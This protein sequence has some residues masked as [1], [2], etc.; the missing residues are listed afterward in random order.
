M[1]VSNNV[2]CRILTGSIARCVSCFCRFSVEAAA[3]RVY[4]GD[5]FFGGEHLR[6]PECGEIH[7]PIEGGG[8]GH[9]VQSQ[10]FQNKK[11]QLRAE[12]RSPD[13]MEEM[14]SAT[15]VHGWR[16]YPLHAPTII[17][18]DTIPF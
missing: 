4:M 7:N 11:R 6:C 13:W 5:Y 15:Y 14:H 18:D 8:A 17:K 2:A 3:R 12:L 10:R 9:Y 1:R 16:G